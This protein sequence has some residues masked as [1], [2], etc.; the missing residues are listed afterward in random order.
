MLFVVLVSGRAVASPIMVTFSDVLNPQSGPLDGL[1]LSGS[2]TYNDP[3]GVTGCAPSC[4]FAPLQ[5]FPMLSFSL[6]VGQ[7]HF[8]LSQTLPG[9]RVQ[10]P[11]G[12]F[13][14]GPVAQINPSFLPTG[15][16]SMVMGANASVLFSYT[17]PSGSLHF[18][19][20][21]NVTVSAAR[22]VPGPGSLIMCLG[23]LSVLA[24]R[25]YWS[26]CR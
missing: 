19:N 25:R 10:G 18:Y 15:V 24:L 12:H 26:I 6:N 3:Y 13:L 21:L 22:S 5:T 11:L 17:T 16:S 8:N 7:Y 2:F 20:P 23:A 9:S 4:T 14:W 1:A